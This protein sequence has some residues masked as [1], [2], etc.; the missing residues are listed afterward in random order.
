M[1]RIGIVGDADPQ[2]EPHVATD[3]GIAHSAAALSLTV[4]ATW[5]PTETLVAVEGETRLGAF[6]GLIIA[7]GS[8]YRSMEGALQ[9]VRFARKRGVPLIG[10]CGGFQHIALEFARN[11]LGLMDADHAE[12]NPDASL[13][14]ITESSCSIRGQVLWVSVLPGSRAHSLYGV[15]RAEERYYCRFALN[16]VYRAQVEAAGLRVTGT[17]ES[18]E[19]R[20]LELPDHPFFMATLFVPQSRSRPDAPHPLVTG[21]LQAAALSAVR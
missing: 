4:D 16:P 2:F 18:G 3:A 7:P 19:A 14:F 13:L 15:T 9:A 1:V 12:T 8:P 6:D 17:D 20:I 21:F 10:M 11:V 5:L